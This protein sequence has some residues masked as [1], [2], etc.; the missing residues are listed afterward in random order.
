M[1]LAF[2][3]ANRLCWNA[4]Y[5]LIEKRELL[6]NICADTVTICWYVQLFQFKLAQLGKLSLWNAGQREMQM[7]VDVELGDCLI[8]S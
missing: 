5:V 4:S 8:I 1:T 7:D 2:S 3:W 6:I